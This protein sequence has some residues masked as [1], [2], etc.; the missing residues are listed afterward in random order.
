LF[1][2][3]EKISEE[4]SPIYYGENSFY[5]PRINPLLCWLR[6]LDKR[7]FRMVL[8]IRFEYEGVYATDLFQSIR[9]LK[10]LEELVIGV[11]E[12]G[13]VLSLC[14]ELDGL[15]QC[16]SRTDITPTMNLKVLLH[17][18]MD[19]LRQLRGI[20]IV[21]FTCHRWDD[22]SSRPLSG[23]IPNGVLTRIAA[24]IMKQPSAKTATKQ[25]DGLPFRFL[26]LPAELRNRIYNL[27]FNFEGGVTL[28]KRLPTSALRS[29]T[30]KKVDKVKEGPILSSVL[31]LLQTNRQIYQ[32]ARAVFYVQNNLTFYWPLHLQA[33]LSETSNDRT[34]YISEI[35]IWCSNTSE[36][37]V[38]C[39]DV[40]FENLRRLRSLRRLHLRFESI[41][42]TGFHWCRNITPIKM[43][44]FAGM[45]SL[46][47]IR[48]LDV[49]TLEDNCVRDAIAGFK[50][51]IK[52][53]PRDKLQTTCIKKR[54]RLF[55]NLTKTLRR[56]LE[57]AQK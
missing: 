7:H 56:E 24:E 25:L 5:F 19:A 1:K 23:P 29:G 17:T 30:H 46:R 41:Y 8:R 27:L 39:M 44:I 31:A 32:E 36:G 49:L 9:R 43:P 48:G 57:V 47:K 16:L 14:R 34:D 35:T 18:G 2:V 20:K 52:E 54:C 40:V 37:G 10:N 42:G 22:D 55:H 15:R 45:D 13:I 51:Q 50:G 3:A 53:D 26:S 4:A 21:R 33:F 11:D 12:A 28:S 38:S 6:D